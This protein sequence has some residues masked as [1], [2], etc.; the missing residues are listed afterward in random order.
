[1]KKLFKNINN[2]ITN[3]N[4]NIED[5]FDNSFVFNK[6]PSSLNAK[7]SDTIK[8]IVLNPL[9]STITDIDF[10]LSQRLKKFKR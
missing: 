6:N 3:S 2:E 7:F 1:M 8:K 10:L 9:S 4:L 5:I